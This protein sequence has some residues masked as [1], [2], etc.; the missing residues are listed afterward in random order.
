M[1]KYSLEKRLYEVVNLFRI[2]HLHYL[3]VR[4]GEVLW[5]NLRGYS[6]AK[7][8]VSVG[9]KNEKNTLCDVESGGVC[10]Y[11]FG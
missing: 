10:R 11:V 4:N 5:Y 8:Q 3:P 7:T 6:K 9:G 2:F 1:F